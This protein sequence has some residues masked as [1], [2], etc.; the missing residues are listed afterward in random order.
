MKDD[1]LKALKRSAKAILKDE[2]KELRDRLRIANV[3]R[4]QA[5]AD[6]TRLTEELS[7]QRD[8]SRRLAAS[9]DHWQG[10]HGEL[11]DRTRRAMRW[12][13]SHGVAPA[14][15]A[16]SCLSAWTINGTGGSGFGVV[17]PFDRWG[18]SPKP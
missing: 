6:V 17:H 9:R 2:L 18:I 13:D 16:A 12:V 11:L 15:R 5:H 4:E 3:K 7:Q 10:L 8:G 1:A 14:S